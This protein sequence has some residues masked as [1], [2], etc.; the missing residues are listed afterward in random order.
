MGA[1]AAEKPIKWWVPLITGILAIVVGILFF[2]KPVATSASA[3]LVLGLYWLII[4]IVDIIRIFQDR[5]AWGWK[6]FMGII[7]ILAGGVILSGFIGGTKL[8]ALATTAMVGLAL[9][10]V[11]GILA[12]M[13]GIVAL[14]AAFRGGGWAMGILGVLAIIFGFIMAFSKPIASALALPVAL[15]IFLVIEGIILLVTA[16]RLRSAS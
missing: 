10:I 13:Y 1:L 4:G 2:V 8:D 14:I 7:A 15:G 12:I 5:T 16:F 11:I 9:T 6:L 3:V